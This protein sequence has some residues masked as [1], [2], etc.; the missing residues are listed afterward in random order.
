MVIAGS[1][2]CREFAALTL[3]PRFARPLRLPT[4]GLAASVCFS[5]S[6]CAWL[7]GHGE[8][9]QVP[10][11]FKPAQAT[12][13]AAVDGLTIRATFLGPGQRIRSAT[14]FWGRV[15]RAVNPYGADSLVFQVSLRNEGPKTLV[16]QPTGATLSLDGGPGLR[17]RVMDDYRKRWPTWAVTHPDEGTDQAAAYAELLETILIERA[18]PP[19]GMVEGRLAFPA[20]PVLRSITLSLPI[21]SDRV[22]RLAVLDWKP[23]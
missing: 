1:A 18:L 23:L 7:F 21:E 11:T 17:A 20:G 19:G 16:V 15:S 6:G 2:E 5:T 13:V 14:N 9:P 10:A 22:K 4:L 8:L 3:F 12:A